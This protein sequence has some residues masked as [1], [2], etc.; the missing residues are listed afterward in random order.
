MHTIPIEI[1]RLAVKLWLLQFPDRP[2]SSDASSIEKTIYRVSAE[3]ALPTIS[4]L[5]EQLRRAVCCLEVIEKDEYDFGE[6]FIGSES[7][8]VA[9]DGL[10]SVNEA[11]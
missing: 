9:K 8:H 6:E 7:A 1:E 10:R 5:E 11:E 4:K 2:F 3:L